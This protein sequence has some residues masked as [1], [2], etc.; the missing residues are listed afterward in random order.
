MRAVYADYFS[1]MVDEK[2]WLKEALSDDG[3]QP[4]AAGYKVM[5]PIA[6]AAI[7]KALQ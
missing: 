3:L 6:E 5:A 7:Q 1:A 2:G 4:N